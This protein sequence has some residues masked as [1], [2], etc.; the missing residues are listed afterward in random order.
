MSYIYKAVRKLKPTA[1]FSFNNDDYSTIHFDVLDGKAPTQSEI[2]TTIQQI[3]AEEIAA[4][5]KAATA[6]A[7]LLVKLG[8]TADELQ[9]LLS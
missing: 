2:D 4:T 5:A 1:E 7:A 8:I 3:K 9:T 6:K